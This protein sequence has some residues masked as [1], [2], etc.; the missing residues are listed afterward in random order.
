[1]AG[2]LRWYQTKLATRPLLTQSITTAVLFATGDAM[3]QTGIEKRRLNN[4]DFARSGRMAFYG[5]AIFGPLATKWFGFLQSRVRIPSSPNG[6]ILARVGLDQLVF[7]PC[8]MFGFLSFMAVMEGSDPKKKLDSTYKNA[9]TK[10]WMVWPFV[11]LANFKF[12][13][14][15]HRV[16]VVNIVSLGWNC[17]LSYLNSQGGGDRTTDLP[18]S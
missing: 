3:A 4:Y 1:M 7:A 13:P 16:L 6:E 12:T 15:Q 2:V 9:L 10:N 14:L 17:Y 5:G 8:N 11:Q 18:P